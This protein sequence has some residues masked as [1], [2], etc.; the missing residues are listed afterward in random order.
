MSKT[1]FRSVA[2]QGEP[3][4]FSSIAAG[5]LLPEGAAQIPCRTFSEVFEAMASARV[6]HAVIP[7]ENSLYGSVHENYDHLLRYD[8]PIVL[9]TTVRIEH[10]LIA[11]PGVKLRDLRK[12]FSHPVALGQCLQFFEKNSAILPAPFYDT[13]G[14]VKMLLAEGITDAGAIASSAAAEIYGGNILRTNIEDDRRNFTRFFLLAKQGARSR[15]TGE[16]WK[17]SAVFSTPNASGAL[18]KAL[19]CFALRGL[20]LSKIE[21]RPLRARP[22]EYLFYLDI[23]GYEKEATV[24][25]ALANLEEISTFVKVLGTYRGIP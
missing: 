2:F 21:S 8:F 13:A 23:S 6:Q 1:K 16:G 10:N 14:S 7:I 18:F 12:A 25:K 4:A 5:K 9:E 22:W 24:Q 19:A 11:M 20:S 15:S 17:T 3:G